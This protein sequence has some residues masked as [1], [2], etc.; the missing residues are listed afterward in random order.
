[1]PEEQTWPALQ[2]LPQPP[3]WWGSCL[4]LAQASVPASPPPHFCWPT[5]QVTEQ[6][7]LAHTSP[8][9]H[10]CPQAPQW[11]GSI[12][13]LVQV[14]LHDCSLGPHSQKSFSGAEPSS[15]AT[16]SS[17]QAQR[18]T[19]SNTRME[20]ASTFHMGEFTEIGL[21]EAVIVFTSSFCQQD[22]NYPLRGP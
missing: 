21:P 9:L 15:W 5:G 19:Q 8:A 16:S 17:L 7:P 12:L 22:T 20:A 4:M 1:M 10:A 13:V 3:Q 2:A 6:T 11:A 14:P 18:L